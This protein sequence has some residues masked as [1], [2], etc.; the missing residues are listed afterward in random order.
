[1]KHLQNMERIKWHKAA[2]NGLLKVGK[3]HE[4]YQ[5]QSRNVPDIAPSGLE[6][7]LFNSIGSSI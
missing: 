6:K 4:T 3:R 5:Y 2:E 7:I 1:M